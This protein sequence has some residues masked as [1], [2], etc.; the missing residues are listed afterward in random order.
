MVLAPASLLPLIGAAYSRAR[1]YT[2]D[3]H[4][5]A[6]CDKA[7]SAQVGIAAL[8]AGGKRGAVMCMQSYSEQS[9]DSDSFWMSFHEL[10]ADY[11][12][13]VKRMAAVQALAQGQEV[14]QPRRH[15]MAVLLALF[16]PRVG[17]P[18][19]AGPF[20][21]LALIAMSAA[22]VIP[23]YEQYK[24]KAAVAAAYRSGMAA[25]AAVQKFYVAHK[26]VPATLKEAGADDAVADALE[27]DPDSA[28]IKVSPRIAS[29]SMLALTPSLGKD[30]RMQWKCSAEGISPALL[31]E[32]CL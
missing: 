23:A 10:V 6:A 29:S 20:V 30:G 2:C 31:P 1:E 16:V 17:G 25:S 4:G 27:F 5:L 9:R 24:Q 7:E 8:A 21:L 13:L 12:W 11:P 15:P 14:K 3:R 28:A 32:D 26:A 22:V 19:G 18:S